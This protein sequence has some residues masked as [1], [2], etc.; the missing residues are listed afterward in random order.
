MP[1][2]SITITG[3]LTDEPE[4]RFTPKGSPVAKFRVAYSERYRDNSSGEW[5][6]GETSYFTVYAWNALGDHVAESFS[7]GMRVIVT[8][9]LRQRH[10]ETAEGDKRSVYEIRADDVG[11]SVRFGT[12]KVTRASRSRDDDQAPEPAGDPWSGG[13]A[14]TAPDGAQRPVSEPAEPA[15]PTGARSRSRAG[16]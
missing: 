6:E 2:N 13:G 9:T 16:Q 11:A 4:V 10:Y 12:V 5:Q 7:K 14:E 15:A 8:G 3:N 1:Q